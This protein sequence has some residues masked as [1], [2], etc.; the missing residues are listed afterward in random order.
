MDASYA[1]FSRAFFNLTQNS[2]HRRKRPR[3]R[4]ARHPLARKV[5]KVTALTSSIEPVVAKKTVDQQIVVTPDV[6]NATAPSR[7]RSATE[8]RWVCKTGLMRAR[9]GNSA[10]AI[11]VADI[12][13]IQ[14]ASFSSRR[15]RQG[16]APDRR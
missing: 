5:V 12:C 14:R 2:H 6:L 11:S 15:M 3:W 13:Q 1:A 4:T 10:C 8:N 16:V 9:N 7:E